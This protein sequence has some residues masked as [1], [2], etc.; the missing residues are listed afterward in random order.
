MSVRFD[1][2]TFKSL[3][4]G[5]HTDV[6]AKDGTAIEYR[7]ED[8]EY[9]VY[10]PGKNSKKSTLKTETDGSLR[11]TLV[12]D[13]IIHITSK[14]DHATTYLVFDKT[15]HLTDCSHDLSIQEGSVNTIPS[16]IPKS[17]ELGVE[18]L[19]ALGALETAGISE[20]VAQEV[21]ADIQWFCDTFNKIITK[22]NKLSD[23]GGRLNFP[24][25]VCHN[26]NKAACSVLG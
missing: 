25:E 21:V 24:A 20:A 6:A 12:Q 4:P 11:V 18:A 26:M 17:I 7:G 10:I 22:W 9:R 13:H 14:D 19:G 5:A 15:G 2:A 8:S 23:D 3:Y 1:E 16:W